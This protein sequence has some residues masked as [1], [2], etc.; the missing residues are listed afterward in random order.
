M[1]ILRDRMMRMRPRFD[2]DRIETIMPIMPPAPRR[3]MPLPLVPPTIVPP[4]PPFIQELRP[5]ITPP[6]TPP[7]IDFGLAQVL[8]QQRF[9]GQMG[10]IGPAGYASRF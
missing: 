10:I 4:K 1:S 2:R 9:V 5:P 8:D 7:P 3:P 6:R